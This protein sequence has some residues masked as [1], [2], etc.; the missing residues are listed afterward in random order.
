MGHLISRFGRTRT[1]VST[2]SG[3]MVPLA[4]LT[5][6]PLDPQVAE[7]DLQ[8]L[9]D[10]PNPSHHQHTSRPTP[11][12]PQAAS[13]LRA[14]CCLICP[15]SRVSTPP[16]MQAQSPQGLCSHARPWH[17][18]HSKK[19]S[20]NLPPLLRGEASPLPPLRLLP[21]P[22]HLAPQLL[23]S[24]HSPVTAPPPGRPAVLAAHPLLQAV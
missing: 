14:P 7:T 20:R 18:M 3:T 21:L 1:S 11:K 12:P 10:S 24:I 13:S 2:S 8:M 23:A 5:A 19:H 15:A 9:M 6:V 16:R 22:H 17:R 4:T